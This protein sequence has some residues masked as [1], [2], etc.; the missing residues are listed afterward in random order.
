MEDCDV[1]PLTLDDFPVHDFDAHLFLAYVEISGILGD[2]TEG[3]VRGNLGRAR[4][5]SLQ[6]R[7]LHFIRDL[8][9][10]LRLY[11]RNGALM[12]Y[13]FKARQ[14]HSFYF[15]AITLLFRP[16]SSGNVPSGPTLLAS[17]FCA[18]LFEDFLA[19]GE[20]SALAPVF[21]F[22]LLTAA[23]A[24]LAYYKYPR[25]WAKAEPEL[26]VINQALAEMAKRYPTAFGAQRVV[27]AVSDAVRKQPRHERPL[28]L[29]FEKEHRKYFDCFGAE[30]CS[31]WDLASPEQPS[32][33][34]RR[35][36]GSTSASTEPTS[37]AETNNHGVEHMGLTENS[38]ILL[39]SNP[40]FAPT[41]MAPPL[42]TGY[43]DP[44]TGMEE[45]LQ[46]DPAFDAVSHGHS[47][48]YST[49]GNWM[50]GDWMADLGWT[51]MDNFPPS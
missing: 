31:K 3:V 25:L 17:S 28:Q 46:R 50:L 30:L 27:K 12:P 14:L 18:G 34:T 38:I 19:R 4:S 44:V 11:H 40:D 8:P 9:E 45:L 37:V 7:L 36:D 24:Q 39:D 32:S 22:H 21:I 49:V 6:T 35:R 15:A 29:I 16:E 2:L 47:L 10:P 5:L 42:V 20:V 41:S 23:Y 26:N 51:P 33:E 13:N 43:Q 48:P 1:R